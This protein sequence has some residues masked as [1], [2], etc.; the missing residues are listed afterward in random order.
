MI[1]IRH[2][3]VRSIQTFIYDFL[4]LK[5]WCKEAGDDVDIEY[6]AKR[7]K[8][9]ATSINDENPFWKAFRETLVDDL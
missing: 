4:Q 9:Q 2:N 5:T 8:V 3:G 6:R 7:P 1:D